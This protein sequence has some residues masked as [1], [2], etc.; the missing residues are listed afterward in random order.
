M[1]ES[2]ISRFPKDTLI[3]TTHAE[4]GLKVKI[5]MTLETQDQAEALRE[6]IDKAIIP[7]LQKLE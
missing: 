5:S 6:A 2:V 4:E 7:L 1:T 3:E